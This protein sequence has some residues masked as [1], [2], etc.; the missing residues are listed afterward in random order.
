MA[1]KI[2]INQEKRYI[3]SGVIVE[4]DKYQK[5][6][7]RNIEILSMK[8]NNY[9]VIVSSNIFSN[10]NI[11]DI[12]KCSLIKTLNKNGIKKNKESEDKEEPIKLEI[13]DYDYYMPDKPFITLSTERTA[14]ERSFCRA[15]RP[16]ST[17]SSIILY[18][19]I[20][21]KMKDIPRSD[22]EKKAIVIYGTD[23]VIY[24][25]SEAS[26]LYKE[27][28]DSVIV[29]NLEECGLKTEQSRKL[30]KWWYK[31]R[32][33]RK[34][35]LLGLKNEQIKNCHMKCDEIFFNAIT[36]PLALA[37]ISM[38]I[39]L[40][41]AEYL[42]IEYTAKQVRCG[43]IIRKIYDLVE[44]GCNACISI[45]TME[46]YFKDIW[47]H[48]DLICKEYN[49]VQDGRL[50]YQKYN[51]DV[52]IFVANYMDKLIKANLE[53]TE[54]GTINDSDYVIKTLTQE[55]KDAINGA[56]N[57]HVSIITGGGG[58]GKSTVANE[59]FVNLKKRGIKFVAAS[60]TGKAVVR[61]N[62]IFRENDSELKENIASTLDFMIT[63]YNKGKT[64]SDDFEVVLID[65]ASMVSTELMYRF[66]TTFTHKFRIIFMGDCNQL[67]PI[68]W[69][70]FLKQIIA[71]ERVPIF[72]LTKNQ[73]LRPPSMT[74]EEEVK[75][76]Q[77]LIGKAPSEI[78]FD[79]T[80]LNNCDEL[81]N[82]KRDL[83]RP[84][85]FNQGDSTDLSQSK[86]F[87]IF[88]EDIE[89]IRTI[90]EQFKSGGTSYHEITCI[91]PYVKFGYIEVINKMFQDVFFGD[92]EG[93]QGGRTIWKVGDRVK[94]LKNNYET[95][96]MNG[97][98]GIITVIDEE[99]VEVQFKNIIKKGVITM[100]SPEFLVRFYLKRDDED[101]DELSQDN[102]NNE[103]RWDGD[104]FYINM[105]KH[106]SCVSVHGSQG[107]EYPYVI[108]YIPEV[109][110]K[111]GIL[112]DFLNIPLLYVLIS[113]TQSTALMI[114]SQSV[115]GKISMTKPRIRCDNLANRISNMRDSEKEKDYYKVVVKA[116]DE[117]DFEYE[118]NDDFFDEEA[119]END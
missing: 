58:V 96:I 52:E 41:V 65:E 61:L 29:K 88:D 49:I 94:M 46:Y 22:E 99:F 119:W 54:K 27:T 118:D 104:K 108:G 32:C 92:V 37:S 93:V 3:L 12:I 17:D 115:L 76:E 101:L 114:T 73:R 116:N 107:S 95:G 25:L 40:F 112:S 14:I 23:R 98:E 59:I 63:R 60:F 62:D 45:N 34:L 55:Q 35:H 18:D 19:A 67:A 77:S 83:T 9:N 24:Y 31:N 82:P 57:N 109:K 1:V 64:S 110:N 43:E 75:Y 4:L 47:S 84:M 11:E 79:R 48:I 20:M 15:L 13:D 85:I 113:R 68:S 106:S 8:G 33:I 38:E 97:E 2:K 91:C 36:N 74:A 6:V 28:G 102:E 44:N 69:G 50:L 72:T 78:N 87:Y 89:F 103:T 39:C 111:K 81:I 26:E 100:G 86:G 56:V 70:S 90:L 53:E 21:N 10:F 105:I 117:E 51:Y 16:F 66:F 7:N 71:S 5:G 80:I 42:N 30:L